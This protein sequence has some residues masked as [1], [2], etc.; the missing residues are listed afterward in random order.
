MTADRYFSSPEE[1]PISTSV[2]FQNFSSKTPPPRR[3][4]SQIHPF[5]RQKYE[6]GLTHNSKHILDVN[7]KEE[8][9]PSFNNPPPTAKTNKTQT[10]RIR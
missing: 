1:I 6:D 2:A 4:A 5:N 3:E 10:R 7:A 8:K 9:S